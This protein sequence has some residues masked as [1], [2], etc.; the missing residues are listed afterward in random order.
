MLCCSTSHQ[1]APVGFKVLRTEDPGNTKR[2][3]VRMTRHLKGVFQN[4]P[5][6][7]LPQ[8]H[9]LPTVAQW[10]AQCAANTRLTVRDVWAR[11]LCCVP[12]TLPFHACAPSA[13]ATCRRA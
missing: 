11:V 6:G 2:L 12:R 4:L 13:N 10:K 8:P 3:Y 5:P 7:G 9:P 1:N